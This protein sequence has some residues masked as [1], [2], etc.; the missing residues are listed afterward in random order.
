MTSNNIKENA[1]DPPADPTP[2]E[3]PT[4]QPHGTTQDQVAEMESEG[5]APKPG[6]PAP[7]PPGAGA[8][9]KPD[10]KDNTQHKE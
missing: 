6:Q 5:Q 3:N 10:Q 4:T 1:N 8:T 7:S 9:S 2:A